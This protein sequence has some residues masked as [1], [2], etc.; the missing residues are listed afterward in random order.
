M[1]SAEVQTSETHVHSGILEGS[2]WRAVPK[3]AIPVALTGILEQMATLID[4]VM[5]G[6]L[7][8]ADGPLA[9]AA[10]GSNTPIT[11]IIL[12]FFIGVAL[13]SNVVIAH[14][15]GKND[16][17]TVHKA[18]HTSICMA[19]IGFVILAAGE[20]I[21]EPLL[22]LLNVPEE[23][24]PYALIFL[25]IYLLGMPSILLYNFEAAIFRSV[26]ITK[27]PLYALGCSSVLNIALVSLFI[28]QFGWGVAGAAAATAICYTVSAVFLFWRLLKIDSPIRL[29]PRELAV[30]APVLKRILGIGV[31]TG[32]QSAVFAIA[33][34]VIQACINSLGTEVMAASSAVLS[35][36]YVVYNLLNS[37]GQACTTFVGQNDGAGNIERCKKT[38]WVC[39]AEA[40]AVNMA[41]IALMFF[42]GHQIMALFNSDPVVIEYGFV[43]MMAIFPAYTFSMGYETMSG[44]MRGFGISL[45][46]AVLTA[47][48][49]CGPRFYW[50]LC[51]FP[52]SPT[53]QT[54]MQIYP[55]SL[56]LTCFLI[57][58]VLIYLRPARSALRGTNRMRA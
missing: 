4:T 8:G 49:V 26:G 54:I 2:L 32:T 58:C 30:D 43:R 6:N 17:G 1:A 20:L 44:Y 36:E 52:K 19:A 45:A 3:F 48:G 56:G 27:M 15:I 10:V 47:L 14:A 23:T 28:T 24:L 16:Q 31:P 35:I 53:F 55:I 37:F 13:G 57:F 41:N 40:E 39:L 22:V 11:S 18:V 50:V 5:V 38:F 34:V 33:N 7:S 25:R 12:N 9:M 21:A 42:C 51:V 46:P 29:N